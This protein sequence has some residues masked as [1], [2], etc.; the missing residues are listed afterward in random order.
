MLEKTNRADE[1][2]QSF[3][4]AIQVAC[5]KSGSPIQ[6]QTKFY[7]SRSNYLKRQNRLA[8]AAMD[9][10]LAKNIPSREPQTKP[11]SIDLSPYYNAS[12][13]EKWH[14][15][16]PTDLSALRHG[17]QTLA[18]VEFDVRGLIQVGAETPTG[19]KYPK[20]VLDIA[21]GRKCTRLHFLHSAINAFDA[22]DGMQIGS[23]VIH[24]A[25]G[26]AR[27][28]PLVIGQDL[29]DWWS[30]PNEVNKRF[31]IAWSGV[32]EPSRQ[33][34]RTIRLFKTTWENPLP[35]VTVKSIDFVS[36]MV[37]PDPFLVAI[38]AE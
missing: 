33:L 19:E 28:I 14:A 22:K 11:D 4:K 24:Y 32:N 30:Q 7:L 27:V 25:D 29:A 35:D 21:V 36:G 1:A 2:Y 15:G 8:E 38:T 10:C 37:E 5:A 18:G 20:Q 34:G 12:L 3:T 31:V 9:F 26:Q 6:A 16:A 17:V 23:Y 13:A